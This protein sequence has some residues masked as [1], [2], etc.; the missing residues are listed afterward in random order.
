M[1]H[2]SRKATPRGRCA[3]ARWS[4]SAAQCSG[5]YSSNEVSHAIFPAIKAVDTATWQFATLP[6]A[7]QYCRWTPTDAVPCFGNPVSSIAKIP[8]RTGI[9]SRRRRQNGRTS[10]VECVM[11]C[12]KP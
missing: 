11:K 6:S 7:P 12:C 10:Q 9:S 2:F 1:R 3:R 5:R 8:R 4:S